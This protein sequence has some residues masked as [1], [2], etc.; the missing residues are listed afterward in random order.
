MLIPEYDKNADITV[1]N[2]DYH[3]SYRDRYGVFQPD[4]AN[5]IY[6][7][8][9]TG[10]KHH[11]I[12]E[13]PDYMY[14]M[15][16]KDP[17]YNKFFARKEE[18]R[19]VTCKYS[20][21]LKSIAENTGNLDFYNRNI[22]N[23]A[24]GSNKLLHT[25]NTVLGSDIHLEDYY[26]FV[27][28]RQYKNQVC[29][30]NKGFFDIE[31]DIIS[32]P[33][34]K[35]ADPGECP[36]NAVTFVDYKGKVVYTFILRNKRNPLIEK[37]EKE[38]EASLQDELQNFVI[39]NV[40]GIE[41]AK[42]FK[43]DDLKFKQF[44]FDEEDEIEMIRSLF[45]LIH[46]VKPDFMLA[47]NMAFDMP[48]II[49]RC[50]VLGYDPAEILSD[51]TYEKKYASYYIDT[52]HGV[53][54]EAR[55]DKCQ[56]AGDSVWLDQLIHFAS[57]RKGQA[58]FPNFKLD[59]AGEIIAKVNKLSYSHITN[60]IKFLCWKDFKTF[61]FY[62]I[63]DTIVQVCIEASVNDIDYIFTKCLSNNTRYDKGHRQSYYLTNRIIKEFRKKGFIFGNNVNKYN[64]VKTLL[65][66]A[67]VNDTTHNS[68]D[69]KVR[70]DWGIILNIVRNLDDFDYKSLYPSIARENNLAPNTI[71]AKCI[72]DKQVH[73]KEN[74]SKNPLYD[75]GGAMFEDLA[76]DNIIEF[77]E[78]WLGLPT[79]TKLM[80]Y[81]EEELASEGVTYCTPYTYR[82]YEYPIQFNGSELVAEKE[83][84]IFKWDM[85]YDHT[86]TNRQ[87]KPIDMKKY[88]SLANKVDEVA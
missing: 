48:Y 25:L 46:T 39:E 40:G 17:G 11:H 83:P 35:F 44:F 23:R 37:F 77:G 20:G 60:N 1:L 54:Y 19:S 81:V 47:W 82:S 29:N 3:E 21:I 28:D 84:T 9:Q 16:P 22:Q 45:L 5:V 76:S 30:I 75:R 61:I 68:D 62:N 71:I 51:P 65:E 7:D 15:L 2:V 38:C 85:R 42:K 43:V 55:G 41:K 13:R 88:V 67:M 32:L 24:G 4:F 8:N 72:I 63:F 73:E 10:L 59:T 6:K 74:Y 79:I 66:G 18:V 27:F 50:R 31:V 86:L 56:L 78:R 12:I 69:A 14:Y 26:R 33:P 70:D 34:G 53:D 64:P 58:Q 52:N 49:E 80:G 36:I 87:A 57:R